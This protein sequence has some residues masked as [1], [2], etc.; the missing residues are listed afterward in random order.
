MGNYALFYCTKFLKKG[1]QLSEETVMDYAQITSKRIPARSIVAFT[2]PLNLCG[3]D[4][5]HYG[6]EVQMHLDDDVYDASC[7]FD[8]FR[9]NEKINMEKR[10]LIAKKLLSAQHI[11][12]QPKA[13]CRT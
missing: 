1:K 8:L 4:C 7:V 12:R 11:T 5:R 2:S 3:E 13:L 10:R 6:T 9:A